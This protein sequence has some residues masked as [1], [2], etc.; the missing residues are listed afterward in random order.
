MKPWVRS[1]VLKK[2]RERET[3]ADR[4]RERKG[5]EKGKGE[6][7]GLERRGMERKEECREK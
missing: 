4:D 7:K 2:D 3:E 5:E 1:P 6:W